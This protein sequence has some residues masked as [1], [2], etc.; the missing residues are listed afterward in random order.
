[1][2]FSASAVGTPEPASAVVA[3]KPVGR[4]GRVAVASV[5]TAMVLG[6]M[7][8][9]RL[10][11]TPEDGSAEMAKSMS[12]AV[13]GTMEKESSAAPMAAAAMVAESNHVA[14]A[15]EL[16]ASNIRENGAARG[17]MQAKASAGAVSAGAGAGLAAAAMAKVA[18]DAATGSDQPDSLQVVFARSLGRMLA[19]QS[20]Q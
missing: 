3:P 8:M 20:A 4:S 11:V 16:V 5:I 14:A 6:L 7:V 18:P 1:M 12:G 13:E 9:V 19:A 17:A 15:D 10:P 2:L